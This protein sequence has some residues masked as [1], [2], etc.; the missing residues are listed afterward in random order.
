MLTLRHVITTSPNVP[1]MPAATIEQLNPANYGLARVSHRARGNFT[2]YRYDDSA[3]NG[4]C[5]YVLDTGVQP[6]QSG[7][8]GD[9]LIQA[10]NQIPGEDFTDFSGHGTHVAGIAASSTYG[11][12]KLAKLFSVKVFPQNLNRDSRLNFIIGGIA[13]VLK[14]A[15]MKAANCPRGKCC[16]HNHSIAIFDI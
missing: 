11:A 3:G 8:F 10:S 14:D 13:F 4:T 12:A 15:Q 16:P 5:I 9:R 7:E 6:G 1:V 2:A